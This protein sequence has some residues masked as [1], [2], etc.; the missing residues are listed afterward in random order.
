MSR[1]KG[2]KNDDF[3]VE[4]VSYSFDK[5]TEEALNIA[6]PI[7]SRLRKRNRNSFSTSRLPC[8]KP[9]GPLAE[10]I[11]RQDN[12]IGRYQSR[13]QNNQSSTDEGVHVQH[14]PTPSHQ[15]FTTTLESCSTKNIL[16]STFSSTLKGLK[17][18]VMTYTD[19][20]ANTPKISY[21]R[22]KLQRKKNDTDLVDLCDESSSSKDVTPTEPLKSPKLHRRH[23]DNLETKPPMT[24]R[25]S[26]VS[27]SSA[28]GR[29]RRTNDL[30]KGQ[31]HSTISPSV[32]SDSMKG[33]ICHS[34]NDD[35]DDDDDLSSGVL[36]IISKERFK[37]KTQ[38]IL[39]IL[40]RSLPP[41]N[42]PTLTTKCIKVTNVQKERNLLFTKA[43]GMICKSY[44]M[45]I[46][47]F[48]SLFTLEN[49][50]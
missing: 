47:S 38:D 17:K 50:F 36:A 37:P 19:R 30:T 22:V 42:A 29:N 1:P 7:N 5:D 3:F 15:K 12:V 25:G 18:K 44:H 31:F 16:K 48:C 46:D 28:C 41:A 9:L 33:N 8:D 40:T 13:V 39:S 4:D 6:T 20:A 11:N 35:E 24:C 2:W 26:F 34:L 45:R 10:A 43:N 49:V 21:S 23:A 32:V 27:D 14:Q